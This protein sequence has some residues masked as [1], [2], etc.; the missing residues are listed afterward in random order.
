MSQNEKDPIDQENTTDR[1]DARNQDTASAD[2]DKLVEDAEADTET[3]KP[4]A[5]GGNQ[6]NQ[7]N[8]GRGGGK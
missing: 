4:G 3:R 5:S 7:H 8:N 2:F 6:S 1:E